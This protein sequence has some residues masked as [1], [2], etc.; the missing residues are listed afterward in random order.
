MNP[1]PLPDTNGMEA[2]SQAIVNQ[3]KTIVIVTQEDYQNATQFLRAIKTS[4]DEIK[5][6]FANSKDLAFK[7]HRA[8]CEAEAK[9]LKP[10]M[11]AEMICKKTIGQYLM[12]EEARRKREEDLRRK[13]AQEKADAERREAIKKQEEERLRMAQ[14]L[15]SR[16][17]SEMAEQILDAPIHV[18]PA[19][20][21]VIPVEAKP[22]A[23]GI[24]PR[25]KLVFKIGDENLVPREFLSVDESKIR[26]YIAYKGDE[27]CIPGVIITEE[28]NISARK[29]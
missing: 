12:V 7:S 21:Q 15:E 25:K 18:A 14:E 19:I 6:T 1:I 24:A 23:H 10:R 27:A 2:R 4:Q 13:E 9:H 8:I 11:E 3:A 17:Q 26:K 22:M 28:I 29:F 5:R 20:P 16:G